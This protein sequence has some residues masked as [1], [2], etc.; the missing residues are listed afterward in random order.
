MVIYKIAFRNLLEH[1]VKTLI[2]GVLI[3]LGTFV[4]VAGNSFLDSLTAG[5]RRSYIENYTGDIIIRTQGGAGSLFSIGGGSGGPG[6]SLPG[7]Q[8]AA[9]TVLPDFANLRSS[10][11]QR[12]EVEVSLPM[13]SGAASLGNGEMTLGF[14]LLWGVDY[15]NYVRMFPSNL[16]M[17][18][19]DWPEVPESTILLSEVVH[20]DA[21]KEL[22]KPI[23]IGDK[24]LLSGFGDGGAKIREVTVAGIFRFKQGGGMLDRLSFTD[25]GTLRGLKAMTVPVVETGTAETDLVSPEPTGDDLFSEDLFGGDILSSS[26]GKSAAQTTDFDNLLGDTSVR[27]KYFSEDL[28]AW[29]FILLRLKNPGD[30]GKVSRE[31]QKDFIA[32]DQPLTVADWRWG[33]GVA[34]EM[35][36]SLQ[37][38]FNVLVAVIVFVAV[39][40]IMNTLVISVTERIPEI[41]T[42]RAIGAQK[43]FVRKMIIMETLMIAVVFGLLG[44]LLGA[45]LIGI[46]GQVG[47]PAPN[48]FLRMLFGGKVFHP[49]ISWSSLVL[50]LG[51]MGL[52]GVLASLYPVSVALK[53]SPVKAMAR[54]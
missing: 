40:I 27:E 46:L 52:V 6:P 17:L 5:L 45:A 9:I 48:D 11:D 24:L 13:I 4:L 23:L 37:M 18:K 1:K 32:Q 19:G 14:S 43:G 12:P 16:E 49:G 3:A 20:K 44:S 42:I 47:V 15:R 33:A 8:G 21:E 25:P 41:G 39:I 54:G 51:V 31:I 30:T 34:A 7:G 35:A 28:Q 22:K 38:V 10:I 53:I 26:D 50:S 36:Y 29:N 2:V